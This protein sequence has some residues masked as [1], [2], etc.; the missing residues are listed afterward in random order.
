MLVLK[1]LIENELKAAN[2]KFP[3]FQSRHEAY[4]V[5]LEEY[6][7]LSAEIDDIGTG[8]LKNYWRLCRESKKRDSEEAKKLLEALEAA[9]NCSFQELIQLGAMIQKA[10][11]L[12]GRNK[13]K[14]SCFETCK[15]F[16]TSMCAFPERCKAYQRKE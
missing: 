7:E 12:E 9:I 11:E 10:K 4:G 8:I 5:L 2:D 3:P 16:G 15:H 6:E 13:N 1:K 14:R